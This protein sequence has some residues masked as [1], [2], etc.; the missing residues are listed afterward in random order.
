MIGKLENLYKNRDGEWVISFS[1]PEDFREEFDRLA[2]T[3]VRVEIKKA[4]KRRS[5]SANNLAWELIDKI[6]ERTGIGKT[7]VYRSAI[8]EIG[9]VSTYAG[10]RDDVIPAFRAS[11]E[12]GHTGRQVE[13]IEG[14]TKPG[15][16]NIRIY[17]GSSEFNTEQ[18]SR[19]INI[20][21]Q[22]AEALGIPT[23]SPQEEERLLAQWGRK[24]EGNHG[25]DKR[26]ND[27]AGESD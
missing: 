25:T 19:L 10:L 9:G 14:S 6:A 18:M 16:S 1:T 11:W 15:W 4:S 8:R 13:V 12:A 22:D 3:E 23:V 20:L 17:F 2:E 26:G 7:E 5:L 21:M 24:T 27:H